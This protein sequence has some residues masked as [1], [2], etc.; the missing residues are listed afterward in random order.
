LQ[1]PSTSTRRRYESFLRSPAGQ[2]LS[3]RDGKSNVF[4]KANLTAIKK[5]YP[6][7][8][9]DRAASQADDTNEDEAKAS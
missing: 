5:A 6:A 4:S 9:A 7:C 8:V 2:G 1:P 3:S